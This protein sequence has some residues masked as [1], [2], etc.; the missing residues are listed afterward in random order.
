MPAAPPRVPP[1]CR[2]RPL[3]RRRRSARPGKRASPSALRRPR[4]SAALRRCLRHEIADRF[5]HAAALREPEPLLIHWA[6]ALALSEVDL[7]TQR[8][9]PRWHDLCTSQWQ[10]AAMRMSF[11]ERLSALDQSF[12]AFETPNAYMHV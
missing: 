7:V 4:T 6:R 9:G 1:A 10:E 2:E 12:L 5:T 3:S 11:Y 8:F